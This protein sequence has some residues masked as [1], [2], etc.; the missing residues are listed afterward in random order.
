MFRQIAAHF[1]MG[2]VTVLP[3]AL[4]LWVLVTIF[5]WVDG[6]LGPYVD[7]LTGIHV[8]GVGFV[9]VLLG[10][11]LAGALMRL[12]VSHRVLLLIESLFTR[13]PFVKSLYSMFKEMVEGLLG[14]KRGFRR[15]V[16]VEWPDERALVLGL[17]T[18]DDLPR[19]IDPDG[20]RL[21]VYLPNTFQFAGVTVIV[22]R[23]RVH[24]C[25]L[26][27]EEAFKF[28]I[29]AGLG[30]ESRVVLEQD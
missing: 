8:P 19:E 28:S 21:S 1:V 7:N 14:H 12:Y 26:S 2:L 27:I 23:T 5:R 20:T 24:P 30:N 9:L 17:V 6:L 18:S 16:L 22:E 25:N 29:S 11:T 10:I 4:V 15:A 3:F 13:I